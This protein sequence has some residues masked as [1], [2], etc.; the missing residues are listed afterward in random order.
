MLI[1]SNRGWRALL[2]S[3]LV[4]LFSPFATCLELGVI[5]EYTSPSDSLLVNNRYVSLKNGGAGLSLMHTT[6]NGHLDLG[7]ASLYAKQGSAS[8]TFSGANVSGPAELS[9]TN[10]SIKALAF[11]KDTFTPFVSYSDMSRA[12]SLEF[13]GSKN[14]S[15]VWGNAQVSY[16]HQA[17]L[18]GL[19]IVAQNN[20]AFEVG[21]GQYDW[22][23]KSDATGYV[24]AIK[25][26]TTIQTQGSDP[27]QMVGVKYQADHWIFAAEYGNYQMKVDNTINNQSV[28]LT[29]HYAF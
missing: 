17:W 1:L 28:R 2:L 27:F 21:V 12:G 22:K 9:M 14:S 11:P 10:W 3:L 13:T 24:G 5:A 15:P 19:R 26:W 8:A 20:L 16:D 4:T 23:L 18:M 6:A 29:A 25:S 7:V